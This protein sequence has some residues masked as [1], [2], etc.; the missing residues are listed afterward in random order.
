MT[1]EDTATTTRSQLEQLVHEFYDDVRADELLGPVFERAIG[2]H[3]TVH[4]ARMVE[5]WS[6]VMLGTRSFRGNVFAKHM[7]I[8]G[9]QPQHFERWLS[10]WHRHT[11]RLFP[12]A[13]AAELQQVAQGVGRNLHYGYFRSFGE[14]APAPGA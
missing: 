1:G 11:G 7:A 3:W 2:A 5:F 6:T 4:L 8:P 13:V 14:F 12:P 9:V 10:L